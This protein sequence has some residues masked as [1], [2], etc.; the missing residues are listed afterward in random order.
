M[1]TTYEKL[2]DEEDLTKVLVRCDQ[3]G[4][5]ISGEVGE[6]INQESGIMLIIKKED[7]VSLDMMKLTGSLDNPILEW[8]G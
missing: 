1:V 3:E 8:K 6:M 7:A 4:N 2:S 5:I